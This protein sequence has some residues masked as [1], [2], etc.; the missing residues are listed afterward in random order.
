MSKRRYPLLAVDGG[1]TKTIA[2]VTNEKGEILGTGRAGATNYQVVGEKQSKCALQA[3]IQAAVDEV[4]AGLAVCGTTD[5]TVEKAAEDVHVKNVRDEDVEFDRAV[6]ALA[7]IDTKRDE[8]IVSNIVEAALTGLK[9][10]VDKVIVENDCLS[11]LLGATGKSPGVLLISGTGSIVFAHDGKGNFIRAGGWGHRVGDEGSGYWIG[12]EAIRSVLKMYDGREKTKSILARMIL[13]HF[14]FGHIEDLYNWVY[15][16]NYSVDDVSALSMVVEKAAELGDEAGCAILDRAVSELE[17][18]LYAVLGGNDAF[19]S[20]SFS[21]VLQGG[22]LQHN[23]YIRQKI[24]NSLKRTHPNL[25]LITTHP[26]P[27]HNII[28]RGLG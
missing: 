4:L 11:A 19:H 22:V 3:A 23:H 6:F 15:G 17:Q 14:G 13:E 21:L 7:G 2:V 25:Q 1:G 24:L 27:I 12:K 16:E 8:A 26:T 5:E 18:L 28:Q 20:G 9:V 10:E